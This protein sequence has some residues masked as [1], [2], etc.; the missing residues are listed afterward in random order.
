VSCIEEIKV[1]CEGCY[2]IVNTNIIDVEK[3]EV[4]SNMS[5][6]L[7]DKYILEIEKST[8]INIPINA[9]VINGKD[10]FIIPGL[11]DMHAHTSS[12]SI[13][14]QVAYPLLIA[15]GVTGIRNMIADCYDEEYSCEKYNSP[16]IE[17]SIKLRQAVSSGNLLGPRS[18]LGSQKVNG[19]RGNSS[20][21]LSPGTPEHGIAHVKFLKQRGVDFIKIYEECPRDVFFAVAEEAYRQN[22]VFVGHVP[23]EVKVSEV[24]IAG[25]KSIEHCCDENFMLECSQIENDLRQKWLNALE[26]ETFNMGALILEMAA[27]YDSTKC[28]RVFDILKEHG[29]WFVPTLIVSESHYPFYYDWTK[30]ERLKY[31]PRSEKILWNDWMKDYHFVY[32]EWDRESQIKMRNRRHEIVGA[33]YRKGIPILAGTDCASIGVFWGS[34]IHEELE[35]L[36]QAGLSEIEALKT[37]TI[38]PAIFLEATDSLGSISK[39]KL[40]DLVILDENPLSDITNTQKI[41]GVLTN[42]QY[43]NRA[44]LD[45]LLQNVETNVKNNFK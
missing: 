36:V 44:E 15:N 6:I 3:G 14:R 23:F 38:N 43:F 13:T 2:A 29:T 40:A 31:L 30:D 35:L 10:K 34:S 28:D 16:T 12:D 33:M 20:T 24:A 5:L 45:S 32:G 4:D 21:I 8:E 41:S 18:I 1:S 7:Q 42:G 25:Q 17:E 39:G 26:Q 11:W 27:T 22:M 9:N 37:A 19:Q